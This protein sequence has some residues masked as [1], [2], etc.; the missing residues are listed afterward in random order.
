MQVV[1][2]IVTEET[3]PLPTIASARHREMLKY[4]L[5]MILAFIGA[6]IILFIY[7]VLP[8]VE[9]FNFVHDWIT[10]LLCAA[11]ILTVVE[12]SIGLVLLSIA[13]SVPLNQ[14]EHSMSTEYII[15]H[16]TMRLLP[17]A[18]ISAMP[19]MPL[20]IVE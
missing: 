4:G 14:V 5:G 17:A 19:T 11:C 16:Q 13:N 9:L 1:D 18:T 20:A 7:F 6:T 3:R 12:G 8:M 10:Q 15:E 2:Q